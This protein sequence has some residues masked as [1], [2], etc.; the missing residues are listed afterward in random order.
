[1]KNYKITFWISTVLFSGLMLFSVVNY[2]INE[3]TIT[4]FEHLG[5][6]AYFRIELAIAKLLGAI[7]LLVPFFGDKIRE[8]AYAGFAFTLISAFVARASIGD[9][10]GLVIAPIVVFLVLIASYLSRLKLKNGTPAN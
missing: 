3:A 5:F 4:A 9:A 7:V 10:I 2:F 8:W 1:M 6:P